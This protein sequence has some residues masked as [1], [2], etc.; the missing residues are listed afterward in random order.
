M[1]PNHE[2]FTSPENGDL[3]DDI[4][5][6]AKRADAILFI[7]RTGD[8]EHMSMSASTL[9]IYQPETNIAHAYVHQVYAEH[10]NLIAAVHGKVTDAMRYR[11]MREFA[12]LAGAD[13]GR[14]EVVNAMLQN[15]EE[16]NKLADEKART[17][18]DY[19]AIADFIVFAL[20]ETAPQIGTANPQ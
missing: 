10:A 8:G 20:A 1:E 13:P 11:G 9:G 4:T 3:P 7:T 15:F 14:F 19:D 5:A 18:T 12:L 16:V 6:A 17:A 2:V